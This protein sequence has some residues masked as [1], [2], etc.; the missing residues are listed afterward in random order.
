MSFMDALSGAI[1][2]ATDF[3]VF[4]S[5]DIRED[6]LA[7]HLRV[8]RAIHRQDEE[9]ARRFMSGHV[10]SAAMITMETEPMLDGGAA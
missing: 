4:D 1:H 10:R 7:A 5:D 9:A 6:T 8:M 2:E 3:E